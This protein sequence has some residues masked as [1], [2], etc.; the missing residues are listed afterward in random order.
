VRDA[1]PLR[2]AK[3]GERVVHVEDHDAAD[4][5]VAEPEVICTWIDHHAFSAADLFGGLP[6]FLKIAAADQ[7]RY[8]RMCGT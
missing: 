5:P 3:S 6:G 1:A 8:I 7:Q 2:E 4:R